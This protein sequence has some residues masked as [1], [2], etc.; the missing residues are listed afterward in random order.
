MEEATPERSGIVEIGKIRERR[1]TDAVLLALVGGAWV[2]HA[3]LQAVVSADCP[4]ATD[5]ELATALG[6][7]WHAGMLDQ[8]GE[9]STE[10]GE[11]VFWRIPT[12]T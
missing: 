8:D 2:S 6:D 10:G 12:A 1:I 5:R 3:S 7:L 11:G 9:P 4:W